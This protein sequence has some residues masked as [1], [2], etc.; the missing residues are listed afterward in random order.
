MIEKEKLLEV[1]GLD[2][3]YGDLQ[4]V[5]EVNM[6][7]K[8]GEMV[9]L[10]GANG[11][12]KSTILQAIMGLNK[13]KSGSVIWKGQDITGIQTNKIARLGLTMTPEGSHIFEDMT[14]KEN[15][16][17]FAGL[18]GKRTIAKLPFDL[19][20]YADTKAGSLSGG[21]KKRLNVACTLVTGPKVWLFD[22]PGI[23]R[24]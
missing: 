19:E 13:P 12:G 11:V 17:F 7:V 6:E 4:A 5:K 22:E 18:A 1:K 24:V 8:K 2:V 10:I 23:D 21:Y 9:A 3:F 16:L 20:K 14:V 15:I